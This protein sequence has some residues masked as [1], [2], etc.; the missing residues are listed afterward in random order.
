MYSTRHIDHPWVRH[1]YADG[2][3]V[4]GLMNPIDDISLFRDPVTGRPQ[5]GVDYMGVDHL[6]DD[7]HLAP[8]LEAWREY[9]HAVSATL[10]ASPLRR[11]ADLGPMHP[12]VE[13]WGHVAAS[14]VV[15]YSLNDTRPNSL[16]RDLAGGLAVLEDDEVKGTTQLY[17]RITRTVVDVPGR[18][19]AERIDYGL[20]N[21]ET[22]PVVADNLIEM[23][24]SEAVQHIR[25]DIDAMVVDLVIEKLRM[26]RNVAAA[27]LV[28]RNYV[29]AHPSEVTGGRR[30]PMTIVM[31]DMS[32][33][34]ARTLREEHSVDSTLFE[35]AP[36]NSDSVQYHAGHTVLDTCMIR[37]RDLRFFFG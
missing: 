34:V 15:A 32:V 14:R 29:E 18:P 19:Y 27:G 4:A 28:L 35:P 12:D 10:V 33:S 13:F 2:E 16:L 23:A 9:G 20:I 36:H 7:P 31:N 6:K 3:P 8:G 22:V 26:N 11:R 5:P 25:H 37:N 30:L 24:R 21:G 17:N 1:L